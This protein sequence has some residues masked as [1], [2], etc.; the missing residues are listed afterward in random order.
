VKYKNLLS[1]IGDGNVPVTQGT[2]DVAGDYLTE[3]KTLRTEL[4][5]I[6][7]E[8][9]NKYSDLLKGAGLPEFINPKPESTMIKSKN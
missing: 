2:K 7:N 1:E 4:D 8:D 9:I 5:K 6:I 3:W